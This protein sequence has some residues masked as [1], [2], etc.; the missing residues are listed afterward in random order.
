MENSNFVRRDCCTVGPAANFKMWRNTNFVGLLCV[1]V[2]VRVCV[3]G[4][5]PRGSD[6]GG[7]GLEGS[8]CARD[9]LRTVD[10]VARATAQVHW[11]QEKS[12]S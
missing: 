9:A 1:C 4:L 7:S 12:C 8:I 10:P 11:K 5:E 6:L 3:V 2:C